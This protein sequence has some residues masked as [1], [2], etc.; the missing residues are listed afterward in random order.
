[1]NVSELITSTRGCDES[2]SGLPSWLGNS[3]IVPAKVSID[4]GVSL[5]SL[6]S[7]CF[8]NGIGPGE[9]IG[10]NQGSRMIA[11][12]TGI[13]EYPSNGLVESKES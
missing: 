6:E 4:S 13:G 2:V 11:C 5:T 1:V 3:V 7:M 8:E 9:G 12:D 10:S